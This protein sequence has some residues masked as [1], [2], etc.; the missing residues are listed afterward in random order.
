VSL[1]WT[2]VLN[3]QR[4]APNGPLTTHLFLCAI[5]TQLDTEEEAG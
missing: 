3:A 5:S 1:E 4:V 2:E